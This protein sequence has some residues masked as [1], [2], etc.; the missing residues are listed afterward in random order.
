M[1]GN[2]KQKIPVWAVPFGILALSA[3]VACMLTPAVAHP[4]KQMMLMG[5]LSLLGPASGLLAGNPVSVL[6]GG[7]A[8]AALMVKASKGSQVCRALLI[9]VWVISGY[10]G[11][12]SAF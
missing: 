11:V 10:W 6:V 1:T 4:A 12:I 3:L 2:E 7:G 8:T 9:P 5:G